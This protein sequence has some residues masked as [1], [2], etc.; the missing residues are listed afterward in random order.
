[1]KY[2]VAGIVA[3]ALLMIAGLVALVAGS[4]SFRK[5]FEEGLLKSQ[6]GSYRNSFVEACAK[7]D[8]FQEKIC[9]CMHDRLI[10]SGAIGGTALD[11]F[12]Q[13]KLS[14]YLASEPGKRMAVDCYEAAEKDAPELAPERKKVVFPAGTI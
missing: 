14:E 2:V 5:G 8:K 11:V 10:S 3:L 1:M 12:R 7:G 4:P 6:G 9:H 13:E